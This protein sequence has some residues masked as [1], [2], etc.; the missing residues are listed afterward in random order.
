MFFGNLDIETLKQFSAKFDSDI[1]DFILPQNSVNQKQS[2][3]RSKSARGKKTNRRVETGSGQTKSVRAQFI[4]IPGKPS[5]CSG[6]LFVF[7]EAG[8]PASPATIHEEVSMRQ[9]G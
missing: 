9:G 4:Y 7:F 8:D 2:A 1:F 6:R 3:G 5:R